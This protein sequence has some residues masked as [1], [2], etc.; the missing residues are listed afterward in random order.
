MSEPI[1][2]TGRRAT[3]GKVSLTELETHAVTGSIEVG[4]TVAGYS[5]RDR[6]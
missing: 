6:R 4:V 3:V 2:V 5:G 1:R